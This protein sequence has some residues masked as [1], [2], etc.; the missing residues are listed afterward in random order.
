MMYVSMNMLRQIVRLPMI[1]LVLLV[2]LT[3]CKTVEKE[4]A[5]A[6]CTD[7]PGIGA[8]AI[9]PNSDLFD[10]LATQL[11]ST[12]APDLN[13]ERASFVQSLILP[14]TDVDMGSGVI[15]AAWYGF[16]GVDDTRALNAAINSGARIVL[17]PAM[18]APWQT[19]P[20]EISVKQPLTIVFESATVVEAIE[21]GYE[22]TDDWL[23]SIHDRDDI[24]IVGYGAEIRMRKDDYRSPAYEPSQWRHAIAITGSERVTVEGLTLTASGGDGVYLGVSRPWRRPPR[25]IVLRDLTLRDHHRQGITVVTGVDILMEYLTITGTWGHLPA[26]GIDFEPN[27]PTEYLRRIVMRN[28]CIYD[29]RGPAINFALHKYRR[30]SFPADIRF[31]NV[32]AVGAPTAIWSKIPNRV[33]GVIDVSGIDAVGITDWPP[34]PTR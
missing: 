23:L 21:G 9:A 17:I 27:Q 24:A 22:A 10:R 1:L 32:V 15:S 12:N 26:A 14:D 7:N 16:D 33:R 11:E 30:W 28:T 6:S 5:V 31:D 20:L 29:N 8:R 19:N 4:T 34:L 25:D 2:I 18:D 13:R 3:G